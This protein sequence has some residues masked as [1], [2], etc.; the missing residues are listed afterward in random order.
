MKVTSKSYALLIGALLGTAGI[1]TA[2]ASSTIITFRVD[3]ATNI[4]NSTFIPGTDT[5]SARGTFNGY[6]QL[7]LVLNG[8]TA[9]IYTNTVDDTTDANGGKLEYKFYNSNGST[10]ESPAH[11]GNNRNAHLPS[12]SGASLVLPTV[13]FSDAGTAVT[14]LVKFRVNMAQQISLGNF[15]P[16]TSLVYARGTMN[17]YGTPVEALLTND[18]S[19]V[20]ITTGGL[21]TSNVYTGIIPV[22]DSQGASELVKYFIDTGSNWENV[23]AVNQGSGS[24]DRFFQNVAQTLPIVDFADSPYAPLSSVTFSVDMSALALTGTYSNYPAYLAGSFNG[25]NTAATQLTN[26]P[27]AINTNIYKAVVVIGQGSPLAYKF[28]YQNNGTVWESP[29]STGG[30]D[31]SSTNLPVVYFSDFPLND[32]LTQ[33]TPVSFVI[34]MNSAVGG[35]PAQADFGTPFNSASDLV[36]INGQFAN[37][38]AWYGGVTPQPAPAGYQLYET[39]PGSGIYSNTIIIPAGTPVAFSYKYGIGRNGN[40]GPTDDEAGMNT[41]HFR[42][43]RATA[44]NPYPMPQDKF[45]NMYAEPFFSSSS[46]GGGNLTVGAVV[47]G[48]VPVTW[49]GRPGAMLQVKDNLS[50]GVWSTISA[51]DGTNWNIGSS[52]TNGFVSRTNWPANSTNKFF[53]LVKP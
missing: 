39:P 23:T 7:N 44:F 25:W 26:D 22:P 32:L 30:N 37:W 48:K 15:T 35:N 2:Q 4:A 49:L 11:G 16:G 38:Y 45:G 5:V 6:G 42:V 28:T 33:P 47:A 34:D 46:T 13:F 18:P 36:Y 27:A 51:T 20:V 41:N 40:P 1:L 8:T 10:W 31:R 12:T 24:G 3:M 9:S 29:A 43:V 21:H 14:N 50:G 19:I 17:G 52:S 53:R